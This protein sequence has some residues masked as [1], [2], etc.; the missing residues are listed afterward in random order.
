MKKIVG[1]CL[2]A[3]LMGLAAVP[4][5]AHFGMV[6]PS[7]D[8]VEDQDEAQIDLEVMF[9]HPFEGQALEMA[10][11]EA[12]GVVARGR[13]TDL[14]G[15]LESHPTRLYADETYRQSWRATYKIDRPGDHLF[16]MQ[17]APYF[18]P[19]EDAYIIHYTKVIV[20]AYGMEDAW[21]S[22]VGLK[23]EIVPLTRPYGF[24]AGNVFRGIVKLDGK[25]APHCD[26]EVEY[27]NTDGALKAPKAVFVTQVVRTDAE[28]VFGYAC[29]RAGWW[30]FAALNDDEATI[31]YEGEAKSVEIG[32][33]LW[34]R[35]EP[36]G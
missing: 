16:Y 25:P 13:R 3:G 26:V 20:N 23:T 9:A 10:G 21:A 35:A 19:A 30:G 32:A 15:S 24:Y 12:F 5:G 18:E 34:I 29:P 7:T 27:Y 1:I 8:V 6:I 14:L 31:P 2:V 28:G 17:P 33:V 36:M 22:E 11:P 4:A